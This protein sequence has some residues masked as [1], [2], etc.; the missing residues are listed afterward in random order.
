MK[1]RWIENI[2]TWGIKILFLLLPLHGAITVFGPDWIRFW[3]EFVILA[4]LGITIFL[5]IKN[6]QQ[7]QEKIKNSFWWASGFLLLLGVL[8]FT[9]PDP[10]TAA[11]AARYLGFGFLVFIIVSRLSIH[12]PKI[13]LQNIGPYFLTACTLSVLFGLWGHFLNGF[14]F[15]SSFYS[16]TISSWVPNQKIPLYHELNGTPRMQGMS[17]GPV[18]FAHILVAGAWVI[19]YSK[20][21]KWIKIV[22]LLLFISGIWFSASRAA[23]LIIILS[24]LYFIMQYVNQTQKQKIILTAFIFIIGIGTI[25]FTPTL[26]TKFIHRVGTSEHITRPIEALKKGIQSPLIGNLGSIGPAARNK[27]LQENDNDKAFIAENVFADYWVQ[28]GIGGIILGLGFFIVHFLEYSKPERMF[29]LMAFLL[30]NMATIFDMTPISLLF[31]ILFVLLSKNK[32]SP[33]FS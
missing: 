8:V 13:T 15:L 14:E 32:V 21:K 4:L 5:E 17:S 10:K 24:A 11:M 22:L 19:P 29:I 20:I 6:R 2:S 16:Q 12:I 9:N 18:E 30:A 27:N 1:T 33:S 26:Q 3:K 23:L 31:F 25:A 28:M 7:R